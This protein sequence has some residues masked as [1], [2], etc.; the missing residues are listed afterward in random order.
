MPEIFFFQIIGISSLL[1][2]LVMV[3]DLI[4]GL[5]K[6]TKR[7]EKKTSNGLKRTLTKFSRY[8]GGVLI[9]GC[10][11]LLIQ[12]GHIPHLFHIDSLIG[13]P[14]VTVLIAIFLI[15]VEVLSMKEGADEKTKT[16]LQRGQEFV[17]KLLTK[18]D[19]REILKEVIEQTK[20]N[21]S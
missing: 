10:I 18:E 9:G 11:D 13:I 4:S 1:V 7:G 3:L 17:Q 6:A 12:L 8:E 16:E 14:I 19:F 2:L 21:P 5:F 20:Q 15:I